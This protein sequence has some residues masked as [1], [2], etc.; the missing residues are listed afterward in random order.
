MI[1]FD[2]LASGVFSAR[3]MAEPAPVAHSK[4]KR[5]L[6]IGLAGSA[7]VFLMPFFAFVALAIWIE[8]QRPVLFRQQ[9]TGLSGRTFRIYKFRTM[10]VAEDDASVR[11]ATKG[12]QRITRVGAVL[13]ALSIDELP[14]LMNVLRGDMSLTGPRPHALAHDETWSSIVPGYRTR[15][16]ARPGLTGYAQVKGYRGEVRNPEDILLRVEADNYYI[17][18]W[19]LG[20]ELRILL[21]TIPLLFH[22]PRAY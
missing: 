22:D 21:R 12:D 6:D 19:S 20:L 4:V 3:E 7:L 15:F 14:Q 1:H 16:R 8:D 9:R 11:Q 18:N 10:T 13:R 17:E 5:A 2:T